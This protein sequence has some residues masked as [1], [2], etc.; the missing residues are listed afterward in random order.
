V[1]SCLADEERR[2]VGWLGHSEQQLEEETAHKVGYSPALEEGPWWL[3]RWHEEQSERSAEVSICPQRRVD[4]NDSVEE[5][6]SP[7]RCHG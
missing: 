7:R 1:D 4:K 3:Q 6:I 5:N 2:G